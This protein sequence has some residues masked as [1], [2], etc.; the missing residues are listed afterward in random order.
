MS[1]VREPTCRARPIHGAVTLVSAK[2]IRSSLTEIWA[3]CDCGA[4]SLGGSRQKEEHAQ[5]RTVRR[6]P[7]GIPSPG[8]EESGVPQDCSPGWRS[9]LMTRRSLGFRVTGH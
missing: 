3:G 8:G 9:M 1:F 5:R 4:G 7:R 6:G 2:M